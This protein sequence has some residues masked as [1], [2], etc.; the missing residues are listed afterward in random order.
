M[1]FVETPV[2]HTP[3]LVEEVLEY[4]A[5]RPEETVV[6]ATVGLAGHARLFADQLGPQGTLICLD[7]DPANLETAK[8]RLA[9]APC[10]VHLFHANF[11]EMPEVLGS[12]N[13]THVDVVFADLGIS[14]TQ[15]DDPNRGLSF[16]SDG[17]LDMRLDPRLT[18]AASDIVNRLSERELGDILFFN[19]QETGGRKIA[20]ALCEAR[21]EKRISTTRQLS[22]IVTRTLGVTDEFSRRS[23]IHPATRT[24]QALRMA[25]NHEMENLESLLKIVPSVLRSGGRCGIIAFHS[26]EDKVVKLDFRGR[27]T[28]K[29][30]NIATPKP[31]V[32]NADERERNPRSRSAKLRVAVRTSQS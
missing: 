28:E 5:I 30:Y 4:L 3:V 14:S 12:L 16:Q 17:P 9:D 8:A 18:L 31:I 26:V 32:A 23:K 1:C 15:L 21:R 19:A 27:K 22:N 7:V 11:S 24:F 20:R 29:V 10:R 25:V 6:D 13:L 2:G